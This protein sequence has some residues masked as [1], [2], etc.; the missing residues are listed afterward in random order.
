MPLGAAGVYPAHAIS[1]TAGLTVNYALSNVFVF[2]ADHQRGKGSGV[3]P[4]VRFAVIGLIGLG[5][6][7]L[8]AWA[9]DALLGSDTVLFAIGGVP[10]RVYLAAKLVLTAVVLLWNYLARKYWIYDRKE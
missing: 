1:F 10:V 3:G 6:T 2:T 5:L 7:E 9:A 4:F 8:G